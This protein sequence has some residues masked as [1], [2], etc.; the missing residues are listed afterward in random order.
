[1]KNSHK[2]VAVDTTSSLSSWSKGNSYQHILL[3]TSKKIWYH[4]AK[5]PPVQGCTTPIVMRQYNTAMS[6]EGSE[7]R[8]TVLARPSSN[9]P[10]PNRTDPKWHAGP[11]LHESHSHESSGVWNQE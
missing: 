7:P 5:W 8:M 4:E 3:V 2:Y 10:Y 11:E 6:P 1:M 9:L